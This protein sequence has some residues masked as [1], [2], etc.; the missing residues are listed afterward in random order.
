MRLLVVAQRYGQDILGG[1][2]SEAREVATRLARRGHEVQVVTTCAR[3]YITWENELPTGTEELEGVLVHRLPVASPRDIRLFGRLST[4]VLASPLDVAFHLQREWMRLQGPLVP[5]LPAWLEENSG[6]FDAVIFFT[7]LYYTTWAGMAATRAPTALRPAAHDEPPLHLPIFD[8]IFRLADGFAFGTPE[9]RALVGRRFRVSRPSQVTGIG[10]ET[11]AAGDVGEFRARFDLGDRPYLVCAGRIDSQKGSGELFHHFTEYKR[12]R[13][14]PLALVFVGEEIERLPR[15][16]DV[17]VTGYLSDETKNAAIL[18]SEALVVPSH[19]ESF[20]IVL[21]E[22]WSLG[23]PA[24]VQA[25]SDVLVGQ[26]LRSRAALPYSN[27]EDFASATDALH[28]DP[29]L[30]QRLGAAGR[31]FVE[32]NYSWQG[33]LARWER[34]LEGL[35]SRRR[36]VLRARLRA[37]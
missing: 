26:A 20:S 7:Y 31:T 12:G 4:R 9:E 18:G 27:F 34:L 5:Q 10:V 19:Y 8:G 6:G 1:A 22:A 36:P 23:R 13:P 37:R 25:R 35:T 33:V 32:A 2:E 11:R 14:G 15:H 28:S 17:R 24:I 16:P 3:S 21:A 29:D 30:R